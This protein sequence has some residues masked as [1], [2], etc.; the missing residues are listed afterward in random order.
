MDYRKVNAKT[1]PDPFPLPRMEEL[2]DNLAGA[3]FI[4][5]IDLTKGYW[6]VP[7]HPDSQEK[8]AFTLLFGK[9]HFTVMP[10]GL[11]GAPAVFQRMMNALF[12]DASGHVAAYMDD[13][14]IYSDSWNDHLQ[15]LEATLNTIEQ[16]GLKMKMEKC[17]FGMTK[18]TYLGHEVG[19]GKVKPLAAKIE[20]IRVFKTPVSKKNVRAFLGLSG[21]YRRFIK[22]YAEMAV[23]LSDLTK[24][25]LPDKVRWTEK[26]QEAFDNLKT[27][28]S[29]EPVLVGPNFDKPFYLHTDASDTGIGA[30]LSQK[31]QNEG[32]EVMDHPVAYY[33]KKLTNSEKNYATVEKECLAIVRAIDHFKVYLSGVRFTVV[34]DHACLRYLTSMKDSGGRLTRWALKLQPFSYSVLHRPG[35]TNGNADGMSRQAWEECYNDDPNQKAGGGGGDVM[36]APWPG[37]P[38][39]HS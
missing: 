29:S 4:S 18:C 31:N 15:H 2:I 22:N 16:A 38:R 23:P 7:V 28:L 33:S 34:T 36:D 35:R 24:K 11:V 39:P 12:S 9:F 21:Y 1:T 19:E 17:Q 10:F 5:T 3:K 8:T 37:G 30:V 20:A 27:A 26:E 25:E 32:E 14:V 13:I 6:Q